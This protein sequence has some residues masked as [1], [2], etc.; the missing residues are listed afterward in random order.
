MEVG[1]GRN[2]ERGME[3]GRRGRAYLID[4]RQRATGE[5]GRG[6]MERGMRA[7]ERRRGRRRRRLRALR[8][9]VRQNT[10]LP[11]YGPHVTF[12]LPE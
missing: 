6:R 7:R 11:D 2:A 3:E 5:R 12:T 10:Q 1:G 4:A 9:K 8:R